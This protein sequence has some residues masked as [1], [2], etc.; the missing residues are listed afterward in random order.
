MYVCVRM[1]TCVD[2]EADIGTVFAVLTDM[3]GMHANVR[4]YM[5][6]VCEYTYFFVCARA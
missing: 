5:M 4:A 6:C 3:E 1:C 2:V